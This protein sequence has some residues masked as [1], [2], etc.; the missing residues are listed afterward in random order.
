VAR[1]SRPQEADGVVRPVERRPGDAVIELLSPIQARYRELMADRGELA[2]L[3]VKGADKAR[4]VASATLRR[5]YDAIG[6]LRA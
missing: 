5:A 6:L 4:R 3:L 1:P 2:A